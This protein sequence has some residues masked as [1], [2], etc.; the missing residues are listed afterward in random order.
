M[1]CLEV[2]VC[3]CLLVEARGHTC[4]P[5]RLLGQVLTG[6]EPLGQAGL[7]RQQV[8]GPSE[9]PDFKGTSGSASLGGG[10][11]Q[12]L[13]LLQEAFTKCALLSASAYSIFL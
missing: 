6:L 8:S 4:S 5:P 7:P 2:C 10:R 1:I 12:D 9:H 11:D 3:T 13:R